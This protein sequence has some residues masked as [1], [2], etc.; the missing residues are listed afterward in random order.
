MSRALTIDPLLSL[1]NQGNPMRNKATLT[2]VGIAVASLFFSPAHADDGKIVS[3]AICQAMT[4]TG[5]DYLIHNG[6]S[7][8]AT[9]SDVTVI[10]PIVRDSIGGK[11][12][13][14]EV[15]H[16]RPSGAAGQ[17]VTGKV[18]SCDIT[19][20][21]CSELSGQSSA[22]NQFTSVAITTTSL[23]HGGDRVF[24]YRSILPE[25]WKIISL[26]YIEE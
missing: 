26:E 1:S 9:G 22:S 12:K 18:V 13:H 14:V 5:A 8:E 23:P 25:G 20:G 15:R 17:V 10:C 21:G 4:P 7:L 19:Y 11:M 16:L 2:A 6:S 24:Y 3:S